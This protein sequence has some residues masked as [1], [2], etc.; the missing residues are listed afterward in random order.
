[1]RYDS[2]LMK[3]EIYERNGSNVYFRREGVCIP[4]KVF[5]LC[6]TVTLVLAFSTL[7]TR[8]GFSIVDSSKG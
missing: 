3:I 4:W 1:M 8:S 6:V 7:R 5:S 2:V